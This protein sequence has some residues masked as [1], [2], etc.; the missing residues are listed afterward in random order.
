MVEAIGGVVLGPEVDGA[1][2]GRD[3]E[4]HHA[5]PRARASMIHDEL[6]RLVGPESVR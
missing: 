3:Q 4:R 2:E 5:P 6:Q 1:E